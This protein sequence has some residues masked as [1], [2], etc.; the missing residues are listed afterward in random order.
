MREFTPGRFEAERHPARLSKV[1]AIVVGLAA[2]LT[3]P[4]FADAQELPES[5]RAP[6][7]TRLLTVHAEGAQVYQCEPD[8]T[9][10][11]AWLLRE[12][13]A[14][15][16]QEG[17]TIGRHTA[18]PQWELTDGSGVQGKVEAKAP[19]A[20]PSDIAWLK[21]AV[22]AHKGRAP[23]PTPRQ[24]SASTPTAAPWTAHARPPERFA[25]SPTQRTMY[26]CASDAGDCGLAK[27]VRRAARP[28]GAKACFQ[29][30][31]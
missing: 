8:A 12:P 3:T 18:G 9:G 15:L 23:S 17:K 27:G 20:T 6:G 13:I 5:I 10:K 30:L 26:S 25:A 11:L 4:A 28:F 16:F 2:S 14:T 21:L 22:F 1:G 31:A 24:F 29:R 19:G 7:E